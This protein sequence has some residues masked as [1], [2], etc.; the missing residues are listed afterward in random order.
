[1]TVRYESLERS[2]PSSTL[3]MPPI[4]NPFVHLEVRPVR[5]TFEPLA[6]FDEV[7]LQSAG[8]GYRRLTRKRFSVLWERRVWM[9]VL[10]WHGEWQNIRGSTSA[11]RDKVWSVIVQSCVCRD[12][13]RQQLQKRRAGGEFPQ[14][15][16]LRHSTLTTP[17]VPITRRDHDKTTPCAS[18]AASDH[19][20]RDLH[21]PTLLWSRDR[22]R[23]SIGEK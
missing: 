15:I 19:Q 16:I 10:C 3:A 17:K 18:Q 11:V 4:F 22:F 5:R 1:M 13:R 23:Q 14:P 20:Q 12:E 7:R 2:T 6:K 9:A 8:R 21:W